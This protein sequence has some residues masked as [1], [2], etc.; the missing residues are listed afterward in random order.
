MAGFEATHTVIVF[1]GDPA[2]PAASALP[3]IWRNRHLRQF[4]SYKEP[5]ESS[6]LWRQT[7]GMVCRDLLKFIEEQKWELLDPALFYEDAWNQVVGFTHFPRWSTDSIPWDAIEK[8]EHLFRQIRIW[9]W[10][11]GKQIEHPKALL[12]PHPPADL[13]DGKKTWIS[14]F[15]SPEAALARARSTY[16]MAFA[17]FQRIVGQYFPN[18]QHDLQHSAWWPCRLVGEIF[19]EPHATP[20]RGWWIGYYCEPVEKETEAGVTLQLGTQERFWRR[21]DIE[22]LRETAMRL[23]PNA[24]PTFVVSNNVLNLHDTH[25]ATVLVKNWLLADIKSAGWNR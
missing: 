23:R 3:P 14:S 7:Y 16:G 2:L 25:P 13:D 12:A 8:H 15:Y 10:L 4:H 17:A 1:S 21:A 9:D 6:H 11:C 22:E 20:P 24:P 19:G 5:D 18:F